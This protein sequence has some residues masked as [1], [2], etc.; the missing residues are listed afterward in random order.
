M[1]HDDDIPEDTPEAPI[2]DEADDG[3]P[4]ELERS[5]IED[6]GP[7]VSPEPVPEPAA[8]PAAVSEPVIDPEAITQ[9]AASL[10]DVGAYV[11][12]FRWVVGLLI[13]LTALNVILGTLG[14]HVA[15]IVMVAALQ[16]SLVFVLLMHA[17]ADMK[18]LTPLFSLC[19]VFVVLLI[20]LMLVAHTDTIEGTEYVESPAA[21]TSD[22][23]NEADE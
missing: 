5:P 2:L 12:N 14:V 1:N 17:M 22:H 19:G 7:E 21:P 13:G 8:H 9:D 10:D 6:E 15:A 3:V 11:L 20:C 18:V 16:V 4:M 23:A